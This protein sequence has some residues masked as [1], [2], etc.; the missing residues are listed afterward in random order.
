MN[1]L[2]SDLGVN[3]KLT[4]GPRK[5]KEFN[6]VKDN[7]PKVAHYNYQADL[8]FLPTSER[9]KLKFKYLLVMD[10]IANDA[11]DI[12][13][14]TNKL[15]S[16]VL[17]ATKRIFKRGILKQPKASIRTDSGTEF[18][19][20]FKKYMHDH[21]IL[22]K[23]ALPDRHKQ[24]GNVERLN[25]DISRIIMGYLDKL[26]QDNKE[27]NTQWLKVIPIIRKRLNS[28]RKK[29]LP[30]GDTWK[31][32]DYPAF[33]PSEEVIKKTKKGEKVVNKLINPMYKKGDMVHHILDRPQN[34]QEKKQIGGF[35][36]GDHR[37]STN[38]KKIVQVLMYPGTAVHYRYL[39]DGIKEASYSKHELKK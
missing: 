21:N 35:R 3:E 4:K 19:G 13:P 23:N 16:T 6:K 30:K 38:K 32:M 2:L 5:Q 33:E 25:R 37:W 29:K 14:I 12:E 7:I 15:S 9:A 20:E 8:L 18:K 10:D 36:M 31:T 28:I 27:V 11:F 24:M 39:L 22:L 34:A 17:E 1:K 26:D